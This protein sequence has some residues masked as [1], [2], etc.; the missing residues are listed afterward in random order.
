MK[1]KPLVCACLIS[2][3]LLPMWGCSST[4][5]TSEQTEVVVFAAASLESALTQI[6]QTYE[7]QHEDVKLTFTFDSSGTLKT[8]IE[9]GAVCDLFLSA[10]QK[11]MNQLDSQDTTGANT[12]GL[13]F[14]YSDTRIDL[15]ENQVVLAVPPEN[16]GKINSF[17]DL[18][19]GDDLLCIGNDDVPVGAYSLEILDHLGYSLDQ[20]EDQGK[21]TYASNVSEVARQV[22]EGVV[23]AGMVY[24]TDASTYGLNVVDAATPEMCQQV[25]YPA[26]AMKSGGAD[27]YDAA[28]DFLTYL[29]TNEEAIS[30]WKDVG[31][32]LI[33]QGEN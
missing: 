32:T 2:A 4:P 12:D 17:S 21:V 16:P 13:D 22:Q 27:S 24:A 26:A 10:A 11:Q 29:Y 14:V 15:L 19:S 31:F 28:E 1:R 9:E 7:A 25:I 6:A 5:T 20:L 3:L 30:V 33:A 8:Q 18:A 23:D